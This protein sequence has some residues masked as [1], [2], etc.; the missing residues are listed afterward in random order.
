MS[1]LDKIDWQSILS[2][3]DTNR[4][5]R[6]EFAELK[7]MIKDL[8]NLR[9]D[10]TDNTIHDAEKFIREAVPDLLDRS[11]IGTIELTNMFRLESFKSS[12]LLKGLLLLSER[13]SKL[14]A[15]ESEI[16]PSQDFTNDTPLDAMNSANSA[17]SN[18]SSDEKDMSGD[19][20]KCPSEENMHEE[21]VLESNGGPIM[22]RTPSIDEALLMVETESALR[23]IVAKGLSE[24][25]GVHD[26]VTSERMPDRDPADFSLLCEACIEPFSDRELY[27]A[28]LPC[29]KL[30]E[31]KVSYCLQ[32]LRHSAR[33]QIT[34]NNIPTCPG[35]QK[36]S[37]LRCSDPLDSTL[38]SLLFRNVCPLCGCKSGVPD[39]ELVSVQCALN[40]N[41]CAKCLRD[42]TLEQMKATRRPPQCPRSSECRFTFDE[43]AMR[44]A[45][46]ECT[47]PNSVS[48]VINTILVITG[49]DHPSLE[50]D[51]LDWH[52]LSVQMR[53]ESHP[54]S[55]AC[56]EPNCV[57]MVL[58][59]YFFV[60]CH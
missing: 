21:G 16:I 56:P 35:R 20:I 45:L 42:K 38:L 44:A 53:Q 40:H 23:A 57:G 39:N 49:N 10:Q 14:D 50:D 34:D 4:F 41:F 54:L 12:G 18:N 29:Q 36:D 33:V 1:M 19:G 6:I 26:V 15:K 32:C 28:E 24:A 59:H 52:N 5:G 30:C 8:M 48:R 46:G 3:Y 47:L 7:F 13:C 43:S 37:N 60:I 55:K 58:C 9:D 2:V 27:G 17:N 22:G 51:M 11:D 31:C 25:E